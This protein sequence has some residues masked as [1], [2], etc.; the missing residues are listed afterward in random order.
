MDENNLSKDKFPFQ[1]INPYVFVIIIIIT[2]FF[3]YQ[4][5]GSLFVFITFGEKFLELEN[6]FLGRLI[7][8]VSQ[9]LLILIPVYLL[10]YLAGNTFFNG[11]NIKKTNFI[12]YSLAF[13]G[14]IVVQPALQFYMFLQEKIIENL[15][16]NTNIIES[17]K[18]IS[19]QLEEYTIKLVSANSI[20]ELFIVIIAIALT[21]AI[22]EEFMFRGLILNTLL[23]SGRIKL[24]IILT[25]LIFAI[26]HFH[27]FNIIPLFFLGIYLSIITYYSRSIY[28]AIMVHFV[29]NIISVFA[30][31]FCGREVI[32]D[33]QYIENNIYSVSIFSFISFILFVFV[34]YYIIIVGKKETYEQSS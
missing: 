29:N 27:P 6:M 3:T 17:I 26:F 22:C 11:F 33:Y 15:P 12:Y 5:L 16:F 1:D 25:G 24:S 31:Y 18:S 34:T 32:D 30:V 9:F 23:K 14:I 8:I 2:V 13:V 21:P 4:L 20:N 10:N 28:P 7:T 19:D